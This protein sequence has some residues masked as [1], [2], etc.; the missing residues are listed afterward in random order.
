LENRQ[1]LL[2]SQTHAKSSLRRFIMIDERVD[3][4]YGDSIRG[5]FRHHAVEYHILTLSTSE[6]KKNMDTVLQ[7]T[8]ELETFGISRRCEPIIAIG[9]GVLLDIAGLVSNLCHRGVPY[10]RIPTTLLSLV[11]A[12]IGAKVGVNFSGHKNRLGTYYPPLA[13]FLDKSFLR[14]LDSRQISNGLAEILKIAVAKDKK[15]FALLE[16]NG[17]SLIQDKLQDMH[18]S[19]LII[20]HAIQ[21]MLD[22]LAPNLWEHELERY[23]DFGHSFSPVIEMRALP[24]LLHGEAVAID[25]ALSTVLAYQRTLISTSDLNRVLHLIKTLELPLIHSVCTPDLL[26]EALQDTILH[27]DGLQ[28][29]PLPTAIGSARFFNDVTVQEITIA[30][31]ALKRL[32]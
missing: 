20:Q 32:I 9:G 29:L 23:V 25:L 17:S 27:R 24:E 15:L 21:G 16:E 18:V 26:H 10:I 8:E 14:T 2:G 30:I 5:Y 7:C 12:S 1:I 3:E 19:P 22:E 11:D 31:D 4:I 6:Q 28:R 13:T